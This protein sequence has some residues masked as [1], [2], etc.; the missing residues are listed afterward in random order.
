M[1]N[2]IKSKVEYFKV[3][4]WHKNCQFKLTFYQYKLASDNKKNLIHQSRCGKLKS[5]HKDFLNK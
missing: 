5:Q 2:F 4:F 1:I 3:N